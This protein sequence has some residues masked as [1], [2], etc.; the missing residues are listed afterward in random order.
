MIEI[1]VCKVSCYA[2]KL[3]LKVWKLWNKV[4][5]C[6]KYYYVDHLGAQ[7]LIYF[8]DCLRL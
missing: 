3:F 1:R 8:P 7:L 6:I 5:W 2:D 4:S